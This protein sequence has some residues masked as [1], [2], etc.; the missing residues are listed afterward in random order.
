MLLSLIIGS[1]TEY[2]FFTY[3]VSHVYLVFVLVT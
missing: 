2:T 3:K 1:D